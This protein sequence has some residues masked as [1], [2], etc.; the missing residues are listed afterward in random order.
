[1]ASQI[2]NAQP[3]MHVIDACV[4]E[5]SETLHLA[6]LMKNK[7]RIIDLNTKEWRLKERWKRAAKA[8]VD[9]IETRFISSSKVC[10]RMKDIA[11]RLLLDVPLLRVWYTCEKSGYKMEAYGSRPE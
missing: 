1:M 9:T 10:K 4:G 3:S 5:G 6:A 2:L 11:D 8:G 7:G